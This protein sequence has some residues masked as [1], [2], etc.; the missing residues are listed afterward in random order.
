MN[1]ALVGAGIGALGGAGAGIVWWRLGA[2]RTVLDDRLAPYLRPQR[3]ASTLLRAPVVRTPLAR[4]RGN[5]HVIAAVSA[6]NNARIVQTWRG[7]C[8]AGE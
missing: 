6:T 2:R 1:A 7:A 3:T 4:Y 8:C 5:G